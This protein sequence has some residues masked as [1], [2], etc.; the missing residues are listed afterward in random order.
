MKNTNQVIEE[1]IEEVCLRTN[2]GIVNFQNPKHITILSE[3]LTEM[4]YS[5]IKDNL[6]ENITGFNQIDEAGDNKEEK[7]KDDDKYVGV[8]GNPTVY[9]RAGEET[10][11][12]S[13]PENY[14][15]KKFNKND[16]GKYVPVNGD[17]DGTDKTKN[18]G[19]D[20]EKKVPTQDNGDSQNG[21][22]DKDDDDDDEDGGKGMYSN[23]AGYQAPDLDSQKIKDKADK[24]SDSV[25]GD[26]E[27]NNPQISDDDR[28]IVDDFKKRAEDGSVDLSSKKLEVLKES[29]KK[30]NTLYD[31]SADEQNKTQAAEWL[32]KN[33]DLRTNK[34]GKIAYLNNLGG[35]RK[36][37]SGNAG[38]TKTQDLVSKVSSLTNLEVFDT[39]EVTQGFTNAAKPDLGEDNIIKPSDDKRVAEYFESHTVLKKVRPGLHGIFG[40]RDEDGNTKM[41]S[42]QY[43]KE[44]LKQSINNPSLQNT[45]DFAKEQVNNGNLDE[46]VLEGLTSHKE[47]LETVLNEIEIPSEQASQAVGKSYNRLMVDLHKSDP[48]VS[49]SILKQLAENNLYEQEI[50]NGEEVYLPSSGTFPAGDKIKGGLLEKV[51]LVSCKWGKTGRKYGCPVNSKIICELHQDEEKRDNQGVYLGQ[52]GYS[53][54]IKDDLI[55]GKSK[56]ETKEKTSKFIST[57]LEEVGISETFTSEETSKIS[58]IIANYMEV[59][60]KTKEQVKKSKPKNANQYWSRFG[61]KIDK[62]ELPYVKKL[63]SIIDTEKASKLIGENNAKNLLQNGGVR[64]ESL[65]SAIEIANNIRSNKTLN[66]LEHNKQFYNDNNEPEYVTDIGTQNPNDY[67][68][69]FRTKRTSGRIGG[70]C[71]ISYTGDGGEIG[72]YELKDGGKVIDQKTGNKIKI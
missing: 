70:G 39:K 46:G 68:I 43:S 25:L 8:G 38:T 13:D 61:K 18:S 34:S 10:K 19:T 27:V 48:D 67:S 56:E 30:I 63:G 62:K 53:L 29:L 9:V 71:Q 15:G 42:N 35:N 2:S 6:I 3:V 33:G 28:K 21:N 7:S 69:T 60:D 22:T 66:Q 5:E 64:V 41:P 36:I 52:K 24:D 58:T 31:E 57:S 65:L 14:S 37:L 51:S 45:I 4:G 32:V 16:N 44:Y 72:E 55:K 11:Y 49:S 20:S 17:G 26:T 1:I 23:G 47:R 54:L 50:A 12:K 40:L 59:I